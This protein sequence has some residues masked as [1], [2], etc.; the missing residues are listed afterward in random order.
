MARES[1]KHVSI[2]LGR[3]EV[4]KVSRPARE[5]VSVRLDPQDILLAKRLARP[6]G[7][8]H[9]QLLAQ[10]LHERV[11]QETQHRTR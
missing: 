3:A 2:E 4:F 9:S 5:P 7:T 1:Q 6:K 10:W 8:P 11:V